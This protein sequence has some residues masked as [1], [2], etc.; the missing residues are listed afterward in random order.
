M[1]NLALNA[2]LTYHSLIQILKTVELVFYYQALDLPT[3]AKFSLV[4][5]TLSLCKKYMTCFLDDKTSKAVYLYK[6]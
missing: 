3:R 1:L 5:V 4:D 6:Y 2:K